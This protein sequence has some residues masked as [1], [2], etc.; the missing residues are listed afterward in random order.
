MRHTA[1]RCE[2]ERR[3]SIRRKG[4][5]KAIGQTDCEFDSLFRLVLDVDVHHQCRKGHRIFIICAHPHL[6]KAA[7]NTISWQAAH[8]L[9]LKVTHG[10]NPMLMWIKDDIE[11]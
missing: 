3:L 2:M 5:L 1:M 6:R 4:G 7:L 9:R 11:A 10:S 8:R